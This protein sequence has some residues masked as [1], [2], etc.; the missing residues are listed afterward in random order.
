VP[1]PT[2]SGGSETPSQE[3]PLAR[4]AVWRPSLAIALLGILVTAV[5]IGWMWDRDREYRAQQLAN[6]GQVVADSV[7]QALNEVV[8]RLSGVA[9]F[10]RASDDVSAESFRVYTERLD[11]IPG[12]RGMGYVPILAPRDLAAHEAEIVQTIPGY[13]VFEVD[14]SGNRVPVLP[15]WFHAPVQWYEPSDDPARPH[16]Y[17]SAS[18]PT[19]R[20]AMTRALNDSGVAVSGF[21]NL[22]EQLPGDSFLVY[23]PVIEPETNRARG[24][25]VAPMELGPLLEGNLSAA[26]TGEIDWDIESVSRSTLAPVASEASWATVMDVGNQWWLLTV[27][28][29]DDGAAMTPDTNLTL[30]AL[31]GI[32]ASLLGAVGFYQ[33]RRKGEAQRELVQLRS[34]ARAKDQFLA[35]VSHELRTPL[36]GVL[37][38]AELLRDEHT[39]LS[40]QERRRL[41]GDVAQE[42][43]DL[44]SIIDDL[45]VAARSEL[46][47]LAITRVQVSLRAQVHQ[48]V[49]T[50]RDAIR[51]SLEI[52]STGGVSAVGDPGRVRQIIRNLITNA[53]RYGGPLVRVRFGG[54]DEWSWVEVADNGKGIPRGEWESIFEPYYRAHQELNGQPAALGIGLSVARHLAR[55]MDGDLRYHRDRGWSV[56]SLVLPVA[57]PVTETSGVELEAVKG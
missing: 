24:F 36:T 26:L 15:R 54:D 29:D 11:P 19:R 52:A 41:I 53:D 6:R 50:L 47:L 43:T 25:I 48:V 21:V 32:S 49:E 16:G 9:S 1:R 31:G 34:L 42:A 23:L 28:W 12:M 40:D 10:Y 45:L 56:F 17:D 7:D 4:R 22:V 37:G 46:D 35:S 14:D 18:E 3:S 44:A 5:V 8:E 27:T 51:P 20:E 2:A 39:E 33:Y 57:P 55:L 13:Y 38:F 30:V